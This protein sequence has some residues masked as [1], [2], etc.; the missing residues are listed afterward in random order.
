M[1]AEE[2]RTENREAPTPKRQR[3]KLIDIYT[4][5]GAFSGA[6]LQGIADRVR[7]VTIPTTSSSPS[8]GRESLPMVGNQ[9]GEPSDEPSGE[10][11]D[12]EKTNHINNRESSKHGHPRLSS[13]KPFTSPPDD[14]P[15]N[16]P[17]ISPKD[18]SHTISHTSSENSSHTHR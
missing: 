3:L 15:Y 5:R 16:S 8:S 11:I 2:S 17:H 13:T 1:S 7:E 4:N 10:P 18:S 14:S 12:G 6:E 9:F